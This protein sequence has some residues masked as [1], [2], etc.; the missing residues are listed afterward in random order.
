MAIVT[1]PYDSNVGQAAF[2]QMDEWHSSFFL[3]GSEPVHALSGQAAQGIAFPFLTVVGYNAQGKIAPATYNANPALAIKPVGIINT[4]LPTTTN[5]T[6]PAIFWYTGSFAP[7]ALV[8]DV[9]FDTMAKK[10]VAFVGSP[11]PTQIVMRH[12]TPLSV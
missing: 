11:T 10:E 2:E 8:W 7:E 6:T 5:S 12:R 9:S 1:V 4:P 3:S